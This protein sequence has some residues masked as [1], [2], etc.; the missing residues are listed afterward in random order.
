LIYKLS[1]F[2]IGQDS[3]AL[4]LKAVC[5]NLNQDLS[6]IKVVNP[7]SDKLRIYGLTQE[8]HIEI[9]DVLGRPM[10]NF[11]SNSFEMEEDIQFLPAGNYFVR[12]KSSSDSQTLRLLKQ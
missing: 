1:Q 2:E 12:V 8:T 3:P 4:E 10:A 7:A 11:I 9:V 5:S 6:T